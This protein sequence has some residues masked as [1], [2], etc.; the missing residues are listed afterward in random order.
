MRT[1]TDEEL[2]D[3]LAKHKKWLNGEEGGEQADLRG[4]DLRYVD[5]KGANLRYADLSDADLSGANLQGADLRDTTLQRAN[6]QEAYC[7]DAW[8]QYADLCKANL[9]RA[10]LHQA[11]LQESH[12]FNADLSYANLYRADLTGVNLY[13]VNLYGA[14]TTNACFKSALVADK[15]L[16]G[17]K[18]KKVDHPDRYC[19]GIKAIDYIESH[20]MNFNL[21]NVIKYVTRAGL[22]SENAFEDLQKAKWY[23]EREIQRG[24][25]N[26]QKVHD[27][28]INNHCGE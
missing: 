10:N 24:N 28:Y 17:D 1:I 21:G 5:L 13:G 9:S 22:K 20:N 2:Q 7:C 6:L 23:I 25:C 4:T 14:D 27:K 8:L 19:H 15:E 12:L 26:E 3:I 16:K 18:N 11:R